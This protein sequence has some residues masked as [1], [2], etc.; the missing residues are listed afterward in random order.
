MSQPT[1]VQPAPTAALTPAQGKPA[2]RPRNQRLVA[3]VL[4]L[5]AGALMG[6]FIYAP[7]DF[8]EPLRMLLQFVVVPGAIAT[9]LFLW[10]QAAIRRLFTR[11]K[12][13]SSQ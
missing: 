11:R 10:K 13:T 4:H 7:A 2:R 3:R 5:L 8:A 6:T 12:R 1:S 9:G